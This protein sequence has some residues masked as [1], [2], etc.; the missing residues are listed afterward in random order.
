MNRIANIITIVAA[1]IVVSKLVEK[2]WEF[3]VY[4]AG[5][6][7]IR[8]NRKYLRQIAKEADKLK[9]MPTEELMS[10]AHGERLVR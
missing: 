1:A 9:D 10:I 6:I 4:D 7:K 8:R 5:S 2:G 3:F